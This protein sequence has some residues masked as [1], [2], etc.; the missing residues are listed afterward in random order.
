MNVSLA[1]YSGQGCTF[2]LWDEQIESIEALT[3]EPES[4]SG[5]SKE[6]GHQFRRYRIIYKTGNVS[7]PIEI[8]QLIDPKYEELISGWIKHKAEWQNK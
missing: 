2:Q 3:E 4:I 6:A 1:V 5:H 7:V 8:W